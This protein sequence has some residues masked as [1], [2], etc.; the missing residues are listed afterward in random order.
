MVVV[1]DVTA[2]VRQQSWWCWGSGSPQ[3]RLWR[4]GGQTAVTVPGLTGPFSGVSGGLEGLEDYLQSTVHTYHYHPSL[5]AQ[6]GL[7]Q[8]GLINN[9]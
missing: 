6:V 2:R 1:T 7:C 5:A 8:Q 4:S 9:R 3:L